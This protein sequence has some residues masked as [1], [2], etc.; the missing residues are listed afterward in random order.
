[1]AV[2]A[3]VWAQDITAPGLIGPPACQGISEIDTF[4]LAEVRNITGTTARFAPKNVVNL[5]GLLRSYAGD[6]GPTSF[7]IRY[8]V[9]NAKT[10][11]R[12]G[13]YNLGTVDSSNP[14]FGGSSQNASYPTKTPH[15]FTVYTTAN[16]FGASRPLTRRCFMTGGTYTPTN[17]DINDGSTGCFSIPG[18]SRQDISNCLCGRKS[19]GGWWKTDGTEQERTDRNDATSTHLGCAN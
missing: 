4:D 17:A 7:P 1:M 10:G 5:Y 18:L 13:P 11:A 3:P 8:T 6:G 19:S 14:N 16:G 2:A 9:H 15:Y 12:Q